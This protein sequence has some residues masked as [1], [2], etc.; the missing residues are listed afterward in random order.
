[1]TG[2]H[3]QLYE[4]GGAYVYAI[5]GTRIYLV[6]NVLA[7]ISLAI[8]ND[9]IGALDAYVGRATAYLTASEI[10]DDTCLT[11]TGHS[12]GAALAEA[13]AG[14]YQSTAVVFEDPGAAKYLQ[15]NYVRPGTTTAYQAAPNLINT[16]DTSAISTIYRIYPAYDFSFVWKGSGAVGALWP[17][18]IK[19][20][21][22]QHDMN[23][24]LAQFNPVTGQPYVFSEQTTGWPLF[25]L[26]EGYDGFFTRT[27]LNCYYWLTEHTA[28]GRW[29][30][31][32]GNSLN[33]AYDFVITGSDE[34]DDLLWGGGDYDDILNGKSGNDQYWAFAGMNSITDASGNEVYHFFT[35]KIRGITSINDG[36]GLGSITLDNF[37]TCNIKTL[38]IVP[39][40]IIG[41]SE[42]VLIFYPNDPNTGCKADSTFGSL[43]F[44]FL[45]N[46]HN[47]D[48]L[49]LHVSGD[50]LLITLNNVATNAIVINN[51]QDGDLGI[52]LTAAL[53]C[54]GCATANYY[55]SDTNGEILTCD[56]NH[57]CYLF[58]LSSSNVYM[59]YHNNPY[60]C[61]MVGS[62]AAANTFIF[63]SKDQNVKMQPTA[64][65]GMSAIHGYKASDL[66]DISAFNASNV[67]FQQDLV[68]GQVTITLSNGI[69]ILLPSVYNNISYTMD[70]NNNRTFVPIVKFPF[71]TTT[72]TPTET[73]S[74]TPNPT[75]NDAN[76]KNS[77]HSI[78]QTNTLTDNET[79]NAMAIF[80]IP[81]QTSIIDLTKLFGRT[82]ISDIVIR[83]P[84]S[85]TNSGMKLLPMKLGNHTYGQP[86]APYVLASSSQSFVDLGNSSTGLEYNSTYRQFWAAAGRMKWYFSSPGSSF[87]DSVTLG[88]N[89]SIYAA[90]DKLYCLNA[91]GTLIWS[92]NY[93][94]SGA[95]YSFSAPILRPGGSGIYMG[96]ASFGSNAYLFSLNLNGSLQWINRL[97]NTYI[98][99][100]PA[101]GADG[102][103]YISTNYIYSVNPN[104]TLKWS[105]EQTTGW[106]SSPAIS[107]DGSV[108]IGAGNLYCYHPNG[109][110]KWIYS[111]NNTRNS[112]HSPVIGKNGNI[113]ITSDNYLHCINPSGSLQWS[114]AVTGGVS[115]VDNPLV[116]GS[117]DSVYVGSESNYADSGG[118]K[119]Y[120]I[121]SNGSLKW[122]Y[123]SGWIWSSA[124]I[125][126]D[127]S[128]YVISTSL[129]SFNPN[130][131]LQWS[132]PINDYHYGPTIGA[133]GSIY[134]APTYSQKIISLSIKIFGQSPWSMSKQNLQRSGRIPD[135]I[136]Y[137]HYD[138]RYWI[139]TG[140]PDIESKPWC[141]EVE[142]VSGIPADQKGIVK[143]VCINQVNSNTDTQ[144]NTPSRTESST[145][146]STFT[147][148]GTTKVTDSNTKTL[149]TT[150]S[151]TKTKHYPELLAVSS[152]NSLTYPSSSP[153]AVA[154]SPSLSMASIASSSAS[155]SPVVSSVKDYTS[156]AC[157]N[158]PL[159]IGFIKTTRT[160]TEYL[161]N[162]AK[163]I[164]DVWMNDDNFIRDNE[165]LADKNNALLKNRLPAH[166]GVSA[167]KLRN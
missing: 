104:G 120:C 97:D 149:T 106:G 63:T 98:Y 158:Q 116:L 161:L 99:S 87:G 162:Y 52:S 69:M 153:S 62:S 40:T 79:D 124:A 83:F 43:I 122:S 74:Q 107:T 92:Y 48:V 108:Y 75:S 121:N 110:L 41:T 96:G 39:A 59:N 44:Y 114:F 45:N 29:L 125:G 103:I 37:G 138:L 31:G 128:I 101:I 28:V 111:L 142:D 95:F 143:I 12:L 4:K 84:K 42:T 33:S 32:L 36:D 61:I 88:A 22:Q 13:L 167:I 66:I 2:F 89:G 30:S 86:L 16:L 155:P 123:D 93:S 51:F 35:T 134:I 53:D 115:S 141:L 159:L 156:S 18:Y 166:K 64:V 47:N 72:V 21:L 25:S 140:Y 73:A 165:L 77:T 154:S 71:N 117:D 133:D 160:K 146:T 118:G 55:V 5:R 58:G 65:T 129:F 60:S 17:V 3:G 112:I 46:Y 145:I 70:G 81:N 148:T 57:D 90:G 9:V 151:A 50:S 109:T 6:G 38:G 23:N 26:H 131:T 102:N 27:D 67:F 91:D 126:V 11:F 150:I 15:G 76:I 136:N 7:D 82:N 164:I 100:S 1:M 157:I 78:T 20:T 152:Y 54:I 10:R 137:T 139:L 119:F 132:F 19:F 130:G 85:F 34:Y 94:F 127:G 49:L 163:N 80:H 147:N 105:Y 24:I 68:T 56:V 8:G 14:I 113:Y 135:N 144:T